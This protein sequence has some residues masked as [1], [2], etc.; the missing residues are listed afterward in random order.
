MT[1]D[2][3]AVIAEGVRVAARQERTRNLILGTLLLVV[4]V[5]FGAIGFYALSAPLFFSMSEAVFG[6]FLGALFGLLTGGIQLAR[7]L[8][9]RPHE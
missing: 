5:V 3:D 9:G 4:G 7:G 8:R 2:P 6:C 1:V